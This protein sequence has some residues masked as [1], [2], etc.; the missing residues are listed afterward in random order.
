MKVIK[1]VS[2]DK[3]ILEKAEEKCKKDR[4]SISNYINY[5]MFKDLFS[6]SDQIKEIQE[7]ENE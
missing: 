6:R 5:L 7:L 4:R 2:L 3:D 1:S